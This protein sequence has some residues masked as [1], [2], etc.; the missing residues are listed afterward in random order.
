[1]FI[2]INRRSI[3]ET[4]VGA[5]IITVLLIG[6]GVTASQTKVKR[7]TITNEDLK[8][9]SSERAGALMTQWDVK[10]ADLC[11]FYTMYV[12]KAE[13]TSATLSTP[14]QEKEAKVA[15]TERTSATLPI[16]TE[17][18]EVTQSEKKEE[19]LLTFRALPL[20]SDLKLTPPM[21]L[22]VSWMDGIVEVDTSISSNERLA[23]APEREYAL[24]WHTLLSDIKTTSRKTGMATNEEVAR[25]MEERIRDAQFPRPP[26][27]HALKWVSTEWDKEKMKALL[28]EK[29]K[30]EKKQEEQVEP[31]TEKVI[32]PATPIPAP[33]KEDT[34]LDK[35]RSYYR[36]KKETTEE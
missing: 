6:I 3:K 23:V 9:F 28:V 5:L 7:I 13:L 12:A 11:D 35:Y 33:P 31:E 2:N 24:R 4:R 1:M 36:S 30:I 32:I 25:L 22:I 26:N 20:F 29:E 17:V 10:V 14:T 21:E 15:D 19:P 16:A 34:P 8:P 27:Y 18:K